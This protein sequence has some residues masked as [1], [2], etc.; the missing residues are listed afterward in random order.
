[1]SRLALFALVTATFGVATAAPAF[2]ARPVNDDYLAS[3]RIV[4]PFTP[5]REAVRDLL[6]LTEATTQP[7]LF[8]P[9]GPAGGGPERTT[10]NGV[11][12]GK[13]V[14]Y[15]LKLDVHGRVEVQ[16]AGTDVIIALYEYDPDS[17]AIADELGCTDERGTTEDV[18]LA[19]LEPR[20]SYTVQIGG[21]DRGAGP[22]GGPL[23]V[24]F[25]FF[26][27]ADQ[28]GIFDALDECPKR[29]GV[30]AAG[31]CLPALNSRANF[32]F[33]DTADGVRM[34]SV[35]MSKV[36]KGAQ[37]T[38]RCTR[39]CDVRQTLKPGKLTFTSIAGRTLPAGARFEV[40]VTRPATGKS[41][42]YRFGAIGQLFR[43]DVE[44]GSVTRT[45][46]CFYPGSKA[47]RKS[48]R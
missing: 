14:W 24:T 27:D 15:D 45:E 20:R 5:S 37:L 3:T 17:D 7:D 42:R 34:T 23:Q 35:R 25:D 22:V 39:R 28:D 26:P 47:L 46:R 10:C 1:M 29:Q 38:L 33:R 13:T 2:G 43:F 9:G 18:F 40:R 32:A 4:E 44:R 6:D 36:P 8:V 48:C 16:T 12:F 21:V 11:P 31:G 30:K 19:N 41:D